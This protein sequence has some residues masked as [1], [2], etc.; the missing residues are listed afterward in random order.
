MEIEP[1]C[2]WVCREGE[3]ALRLME[4]GREMHSDDY[5]WIRSFRAFLYI[6]KIKR[7]REAFFIYCCYFF[8]DVSL[9]I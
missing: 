3:G 4:S 8:V 1:G 7:I 6:C 9:F 5:R 2:S